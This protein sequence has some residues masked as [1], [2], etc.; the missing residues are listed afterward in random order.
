MRRRIRHAISSCSLIVCAHAAAVPP[1][2]SGELEGI[3][4]G[5]CS[6]DGKVSDVRGEVCVRGA[7]DAREVS[8]WGGEYRLLHRPNSSDVTKGSERTLEVVI[9]HWNEKTRTFSFDRNRIM[10][11]PRRNERSSVVHRVQWMRLVGADRME[12]GAREL[13]IQGDR[14][15]ETSFACKLT[16]VR[17]VVERSGPNV[18]PQ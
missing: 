11:D 4:A 15:K 5:T 7:G 10:W 6:D 3:W 18:C 13:I 9:N 1:D 12:E 2:S 16:R 17:R 14:R 8:I